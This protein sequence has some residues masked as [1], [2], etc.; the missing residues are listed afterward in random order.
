MK[1]YPVFITV[2][3]ILSL[4]FASGFGMLVWQL[5]VRFQNQSALKKEEDKFR[6]FLK[7]TAPTQENLAAA[8]ENLRQM[9][10]REK[11]IFTK[12]QG[13]KQFDSKAQDATELVGRL[14]ESS[15]KL[16]K[17]AT[18]AGATIFAP[19]NFGFGFRRYIAT[20]EGQ[21][22]MPP[23]PRLTDIAL[24][25]DVIEFLIDALVGAK[26]SARNPLILQSVLRE[27]VEL[28]QEKNTYI[29]SRNNVDE[30]TPR[31]E[32]TLRRDGI[33]NTYYFRLVFTARTDVLRRF[34]DT[35]S[36]SGYP[37]YVRG[38]AVLPARPPILAELTPPAPT[39]APAPA[40]ADPASTLPPGFAPAA[41]AQSLPPGFSAPGSPSPTPSQPPSFAAAPA[42]SAA[43]QPELPPPVTDAPSEFTVSFEYIIPIP[44]KTETGTA[45]KT[46]K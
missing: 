2:I 28:S 7:E 30:Y 35:V 5:S 14:R 18:T 42:A 22:A 33:A 44:R 36:K 34:L 9:N 6:N 26:E 24:Q 19:A 31:P 8:R 39:A 4:L 16:T 1:K 46:A 43:A 25:K 37:L 15:E 40:A 41:P 29:P 17:L 3:V 45:S 27:P 20:T 21:A 38:V 12:L 23:V 11:E 10:A 13:V 32:E